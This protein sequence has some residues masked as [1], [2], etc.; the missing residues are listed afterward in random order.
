MGVRKGNFQ[1]GVV[2]AFLGVQDS[3]KVCTV[4]YN[5]LLVMLFLYDSIHLERST[6]HLQCTKLICNDR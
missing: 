3:Q 1:A 6:E 5:V 4:L 2:L